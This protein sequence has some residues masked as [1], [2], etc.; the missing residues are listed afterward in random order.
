MKSSCVIKATNLKKAYICPTEVV[1][2]INGL[3]LE[4]NKGD[5]VLIYGPSGSGKST[6]LN[7]LAGIDKVD[8]GDIWFMGE[9]YTQ[10]S[11]R[12]LTSMRRN[13]LGV[14]FQ[15]FELITVMSCYENIEYPLLL[16][17]VSEA[18]RKKRVKEIAALLD[19]ENLLYRK[20]TMISGGQKQRVAICRALVG[21]Y[22]TI[23]GDEITGNLDPVM[24][25]RIFELLGNMNKLSSRTFIMVTHNVSLKKYASR[26]FHLLNGTL[27]EELL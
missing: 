12:M 24:S 10:K 7:I 26:V 18:E 16:Q 23:L 8:E 6:L 2:P 27:Q 14:I 3:H 21:N 1:R 4:V 15:S 19:I 13:Q 20:P 9:K 17:G 22:G 5:F 25:E 11:D